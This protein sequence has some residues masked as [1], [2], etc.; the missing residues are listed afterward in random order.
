MKFVSDIKPESIF[1]D[2]SVA[3]MLGLAVALATIVVLTVTLFTRCCFN[4]SKSLQRQSRSSLN[5]RA[6]PAL[7]EQKRVTPP[8]ATTTTVTSSNVWKEPVNDGAY[9][10]AKIALQKQSIGQYHLPGL[11]YEDQQ[12]GLQHYPQHGG[13]SLQQQERYVEQTF[14][15]NHGSGANSHLYNYVDSAPSS[16]SGGRSGKCSNPDQMYQHARDIV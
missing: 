16:R 4:K 14:S 8:A 9:C 11:H 5:Y 12:F 15:V 10:C 3:A 6:A 7:L 2:Y 1:A 13:E